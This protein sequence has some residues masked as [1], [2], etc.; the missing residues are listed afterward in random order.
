M[1]LIMDLIMPERL[2]AIVIRFLL[3]GWQHQDPHYH[4]KENLNGMMVTPGVPL[5]SERKSSWLD[6]N[7]GFK[8]PSESKFFGLDGNTRIQI[9][10][11][12]EIFLA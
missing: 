2:N 12:K 7:T 10:I 1:D 4:C 5:P 8:L 11:R 9:T 6:G 3:T